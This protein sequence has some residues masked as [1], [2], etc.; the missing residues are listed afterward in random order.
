[1]DGANR[2]RENL[3]EYD[4]AVQELQKNRK[5]LDGVLGL[6]K[7]PGDAACHEILDKQ[8]ETLCKETAEDGTPEEAAALLEEI[9]HT[10]RNWKGPEYARLMLTA[11]QR[12]T[13]PVIPKL[14]PESRKTLCAWYEKEYPRRKRLPVQ[15]Q[16][17]KALQK[18]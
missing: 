14:T 2:L 5:M 18:G 12:H 10:E 16:V 15:D 3:R 7:H 1:M 17:M 13:I 9:Y 6:G 4:Q 8:I 11:V